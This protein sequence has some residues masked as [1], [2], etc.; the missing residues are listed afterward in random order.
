MIYYKPHNVWRLHLATLP[1]G[2]KCLDVGCGTGWWCN[3]A[4]SENPTYDFTGID[5]AEHQPTGEQQEPNVRWVAPVNFHSG[6]WLV[7]PG[8]FNLVHAALLCGCI[9]D[10][11]D[12]YRNVFR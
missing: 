7:Q 8:S 5:I 9:P 3:R 6:D 4:G 2:A 11:P 10:Y 12:F 1:R